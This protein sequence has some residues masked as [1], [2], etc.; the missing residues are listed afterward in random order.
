LYIKDLQ[1]GETYE[2]T[3][4]SFEIYL[5]AGEYFDRFVLTF[6]PRLK[7]IEEIELFEGISITMNNSTE[8]LQLKKIID[9]EIENIYL[10]NIL[11]QKIKEWNSNLIGRMIS[12]PINSDAGAYI[13]YIKTS[14]GYI[15]KKIIK[16]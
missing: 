5:E 15:S 9:V 13:V 12:L 6:R 14:E 4:N 2:I 11:G 3:H 10:F 8:E 1:S 7:T 16:A